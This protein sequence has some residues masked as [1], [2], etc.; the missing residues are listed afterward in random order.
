MKQNS[1]WLFKQTFALDSRSGRLRREDLSNVQ[2]FDATRRFSCVF[3][4]TSTKDAAKLNQHL[5]AAGIRVYLAHDTRETEVLLAIS[6]AKII[7]D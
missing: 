5:S 2:L 7:V 3:L 6:G 1:E 4:S